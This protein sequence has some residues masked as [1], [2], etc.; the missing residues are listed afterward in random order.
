MK[1]MEYGC[2]T[3]GGKWQPFYILLDT[4]MIYFSFAIAGSTRVLEESRSVLE[5]HWSTHA[6]IFPPWWLPQCRPSWRCL[7]WPW[8]RVHDHNK[9]CR[10]WKNQGSLCEDQPVATDESVE[11]GGLELGAIQ[12]PLP[13]QQHPWCWKG[14]MYRSSVP[15]LVSSLLC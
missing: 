5:A 12:P 2:L 6:A 7:G 8:M 13:L 15:G 14:R 11:K 3:N 4:F 10:W 9:L 1:H